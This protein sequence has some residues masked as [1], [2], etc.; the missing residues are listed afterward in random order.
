MKTIDVWQMA[1]EFHELAPNPYIVHG[2]TNYAIPSLHWIKGAF[3]KDWKDFLGMLKVAD[4]SPSANDCD[5]FARLCAT[6]AQIC[7][8]RTKGHPEDTGLA[9]CEVW[10]QSPQ[11]LHAANAFLYGQTPSLGFYEPQAC[12]VVTLTDKE[13]QSINYVR[14]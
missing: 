8:H 7:H 14:F 12:K 6:L 9:F 10:Y 4:Y 13:K 5:D 2:D 11:G 1:E 3:T